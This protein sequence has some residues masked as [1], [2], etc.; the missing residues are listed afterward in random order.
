MSWKIANR[1]PSCEIQGIFLDSHNRTNR[2]VHEMVMLFVTIGLCAAAIASAI[3]A[4]ISSH[5][6]K[7]TNQNAEETNQN[8]EKARQQKILYDLMFEY[9]TVQMLTAVRSLYE[10]H[11]EYTKKGKNLKAIYENTERVDKEKYRKLP[12][13]EKNIFLKNTLNN[14]R[15]L[16]SQFY[17]IMKATLDLKLVPPEYI[18]RYWHSGTLRIIPEIIGPLGQDNDKYLYKLF[19]QAIAYE[20]EQGGDDKQVEK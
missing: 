7:K 8:A 19:D 13:G 10:F 12:E 15:R 9:R 1:R 3:F 11:E 4:G 20:K 6:A 5:N 17:A 16:V 14:Q 2:I 18:F